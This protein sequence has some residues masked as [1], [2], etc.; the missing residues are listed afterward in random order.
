MKTCT[1]CGESRPVDQFVR[2]AT[3]TDGRYPSCKICRRQWHDQKM[4]HDAAYR[5]GLQ[6]RKKAW[7]EENIERHALYKRAWHLQDKY[8]LSLEAY[9]AL[10]VQQDGKCAIC[11]KPH[12]GCGDRPLY[13]DHCHR[14]GRVRGLICLSCNTLL[15][16]CEDSQAL[17]EAA[18]RYLSSPPAQAILSGLPE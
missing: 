8:D 14:T 15:G 13:V 9:D 16:V 1:K 6:D 18:M 12:S 4:R 11:S 7:V 10:L 2:D 5:Q 3:R 17:I